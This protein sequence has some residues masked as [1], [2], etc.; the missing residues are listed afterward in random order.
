MAIAN[1]GAISFDTIQTEFGGTNPISLDEYYAGG[2]FVAAGIS[3]TNG[4]VPSSGAISMNQFYGTAKPPAAGQQAY[5]T[6]GTYSWVA[7]AGVTSVSAVAVGPGRNAGG[8]LGYRNNISVTGGSSYTVV[9]GN[10]GNNVSQANF[11]D[12][13]FINSSTVR[14]GN[15]ANRGNDLGGSFTGDGG[16]DGGKLNGGPAGGAGG[17][18]GKGGDGAFADISYGSIANRTG[19]PGVGGG[20]GGGGGSRNY[21]CYD[22]R[23]G[24]SGGGGGVGLLGQGS[25]GAGGIGANCYGGGGGGGS[26]G[27]NGGPSPQC[28]LGDGGN[29]GGGGRQTRACSGNGAVRLIWPGTARQFPST[30]TANE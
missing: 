23:R 8:G 28:S 5:T 7:P 11:T 19:S 16:G 14:G 26:G 10:G 15:G 6:S 9:V 27:T 17:Y 1:T 29:Y 3:G 22:N 18:S 21:V 30:R 4:A 2:S 20:G 24:Y 12:S 25:N 13:Y